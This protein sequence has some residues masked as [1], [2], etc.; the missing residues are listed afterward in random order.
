MCDKFMM[1][2]KK[3]NILELRVFNIKFNV[4]NLNKTEDKDIQFLFE[5]FRS[6]LKKL[7]YQK[8]E[9]KAM[10]ELFQSLQKDYKNFMDKYEE[11]IK[12]HKYI[13]LSDYFNHKE[14]VLAEHITKRFLN[15]TGEEK[16]FR[17][18]S[19]MIDIIDGEDK[20]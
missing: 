8:N 14:R 2:N 18:I 9:K 4:Q 3:N 13:D 16:I 19:K 10:A 11:I 15:L 7:E 5:I 17:I 12:K 6:A 1:N 20:L